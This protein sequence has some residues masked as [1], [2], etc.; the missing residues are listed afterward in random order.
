MTTQPDELP[1]TIPIPLHH[2][3][4]NALLNAL[5]Y[6]DGHQRRAGRLLGISER[7]MSYKMKRYNVPRIH[8]EAVG[9]PSLRDRALAKLTPTDRRILGIEGVKE[10]HANT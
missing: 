3:V 2:V 7:V 6:T 10:T 9:L 8:A 5:A 1:A 4:R